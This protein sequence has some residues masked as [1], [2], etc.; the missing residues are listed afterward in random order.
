MSDTMSGLDPRKM[1]VTELRSELQR[2]GLDCRGL[3]AE[4]SDRLQEALDSELLGGEEERPAGSLGLEEEERALEPGEGE[5]EEDDDDDAAAALVPE[6]D[7]DDDDDATAAVSSNDQAAPG[8]E[9]SVPAAGSATPADQQAEKMEAATASGG[10]LNGKEATGKAAEKDGGKAKASVGEVEKKDKHS[11]SKG[12]GAMRHGMKRMREDEQRGRT[13]HEYREEG[14]Y[15]RSKSPV[16]A[17]EASDEVDDSEVCLD[18]STCDLQFKMDKDRFGG[19]PLFAERFP[20]LWSGSRATHGVTKGKAYF[21]VKVTKNLPVKEGSTES[22]LLRVGWSVSKSAPQL[23]EDD[24]S[25]AYDSR[26]LKV[27][28]SHFEAYGESIGENDVVGCTANLDGDLVQIFFSKNGV[29]L[30][31]A[32]VLDK[33]TLSEQALLPH[34]LC[35]GCTFQVNFG[36]KEEPWHLPPDGFTFLKGIQ[37]EDLTRMPLPPSTVEECEVLLMIG[38][39][40][41]GKTTWA[42]KHIQE[43][44]E[45]RFQLLSTEALLPQL[46]TTGPDAQEENQKVQ[47][48][49]VQLATQCLI[50]LVP[51]AARRK[52]NY[53]I[54]QCTVY[55]SAQRRKMHCFKGFQRTAVMLVLKDEE[56]QKRLETRKEKG[57][58]IPEYVLLEMKANFM[59]PTKSDLLEDVLYAEL[60]QE[61]AD[62]LILE[63]K[64]E[65]R[66]Q[67]PANDKRGNRMQKRVRTDRGRGGGGGNFNQQVTFNSRMHLQHS[68]PQPYHQQPRSY[69]GS[70][71]GGYQNYFDRYSEQQNRYYG[72]QNFRP[73]NRGWQNYDDRSQYWDYYGYQGY[74]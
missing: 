39:P 3:K 58:I 67:L 34:V 15:S 65:A 41:T 64:K 57:E 40:G 24:L 71:R 7:D 25:Y 13:Y 38:L 28:G 8:K 12:S 44:P 33:S 73:Q 11:D 49:L 30:G 45:K 59:I 5:E 20:S 35:K 2:R 63:A 17:E 18:K 61:E 10:S 42:Q 9:P 31:Q 37:P 74:R 50:R 19:Q 27:T 52:G 54:D 56:W 23:G 6:E 68:R 26:G 72:Q 43:N 55:F 69:W 32:F 36:Q 46:K 22:P 16:P 14:N 1:K 70:Q 60:G 53:I 21:E 66:R 47:D 51:V 29:A 62:T 4:L 48:N